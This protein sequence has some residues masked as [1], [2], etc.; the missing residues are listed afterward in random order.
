M[1]KTLHT[2][3][4]THDLLS[5]ESKPK[6]RGLL[7]AWVQWG[8]AIYTYMNKKNK[9]WKIRINSSVRKGPYN[10]RNSKVLRKSKE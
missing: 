2:H 5:L 1:Y 8:W 10:R 7:K 4:H 3:T 9:K 6:R